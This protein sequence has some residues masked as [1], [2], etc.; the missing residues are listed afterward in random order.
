MFVN[1]V[2]L[3]KEPNLN[4]IDFVFVFLLLILFISTS[5]FIISFLLL[6]LTCSSFLNFL[7]CEIELLLE[8]FFS[9]PI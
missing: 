8:I 7:R 5:N 3:F 4:F 1:Y 6:A 2:D 9:L